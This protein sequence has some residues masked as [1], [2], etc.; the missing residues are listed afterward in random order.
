MRQAR[1]AIAARYR[2]HIRPF[3]VEADR[4]PD[5]YVIG[6]QK[7]GTTFLAG[8]LGQHPAILRPKVKELHY[9]DKY[10]HFGSR[11]YRSNFVGSRSEARSASTASAR[12][13]FEATPDYLYHPAA[14]RRIHA[15]SPS[16]KLIVSLR[17]PVERGV[18][19]YKHMRRAGLETRSVDEALIAD[20]FNL[21]GAADG[22]LTPEQNYFSYVDRGRYHPQ[23]QRFLD[24]FGRDQIHIMFFSD[25]TENPLRA[26]EQ[27][28]AFL[29]LANE[30]PEQLSA[31]NVG[32]GE[33]AA[34]AA[35]IDHV[36]A[37]TAASDAAL[38]AF[39]DVAPRW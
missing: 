33:A 2:R 29:G 34:S 25:L 19:Q 36:R 31:L 9:F 4:G 18:S 17:D 8:L 20:E 13:R 30:P 22:D 24:Y 35:A 3:V 32:A 21:A 1:D 38:W 28:Y 5:F 7:A 39:L 26:L 10:Y 23:L 14:A 37:R 15:F 27:A 11:W 12:Q 16:A 6:A